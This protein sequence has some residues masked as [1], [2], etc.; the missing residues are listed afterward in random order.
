MCFSFVQALANAP[1]GAIARIGNP[2][3]FIQSPLG[4]SNALKLQTNKVQ[5][6]A[7]LA[8]VKRANM[9]TTVARTQSITIPKP[10]IKFSQGE[11]C[12]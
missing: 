1:P 2:T 5:T 9:L 7:A 3:S 8:G 4:V 11:T 10:V 6:A 12:L